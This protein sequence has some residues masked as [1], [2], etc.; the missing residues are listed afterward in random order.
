V[1]NPTCPVTGKPAVRLVQWVSTGFLLTLWRI[2]FRVDAGSSLGRQ[3][4][5]GLWESPTG[6]YFFDPAPEGDHTFYTQFY[7]YLIKHKL[8]SHDA[9]RDEFEVA[10]RHI[11]P[12]HRVL[13]VGCGFASFRRVI[14]NAHYVGLDPNFAG[15]V[16]GAPVIGET[17]TEHL[18]SHAGFYDV[19]CA[20]EVIEHLTSPVAMFVDMV[21]ATRPGGLVIVGVPHHPSAL[22]RIPNFLLNAPPHHLTW[23][24]EAALRALA[25]R[26]GVQVESVERARWCA[27]DSLMY[28]MAR[29]CPIRCRDIHYRAAV[30][31]YVAAVV[32]FL[33]GRLAYAFNKEPRAND[34]GAALV[35]VA[36]RPA[37]GLTA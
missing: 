28:W 13:D 1:T 11:E 20:F 22:S 5:F 10:A 17:L 3:E 6:L 8:W 9:I 14:P 25:E 2:M 21:R 4:R 36:R 34:E 33:A 19:V 37:G 27:T 29:C 18:A 31:W 30:S 26:G 35:M 32:G 24:T 23:W 12:G 15:H 7:D 16:E